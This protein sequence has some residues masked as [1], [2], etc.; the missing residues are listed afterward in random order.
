M[1]SRPNIHTSSQLFS[2]HS[3][4]VIFVLHNMT[5]KLL[6]CIP[7]EKEHKTSLKAIKIF[8]NQKHDTMK[9][10]FHLL[11][12]LGFHI[13]EAYN[14]YESCDYFTMLYNLFKGINLLINVIELLHKNR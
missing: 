2:P 1:D 12:E 4:P 11:P 10:I 9:K 7:L 13:I 14:N 3:T 6:F 8:T 5:N